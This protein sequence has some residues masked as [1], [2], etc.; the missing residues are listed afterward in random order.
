[1]S[2]RYGILIDVNGN[3]VEVE[4]KRKRKQT[5]Q[6]ESENDIDSEYEY[7]SES[8]FESF[9]EDELDGIDTINI[10]H[11]N[12]KKTKTKFFK[13]MVFTSGKYDQYERSSGFNRNNWFGRK[14]RNTNIGICEDKIYEKEKK[15]EKGYEINDFVVDS[16]SEDEFEY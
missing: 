7:E 2:R 8:E 6:S 14:G 1:M 9:S 11:N 4:A 16:D 12:R 3:E 10:I 13:D 5:S 15:Y